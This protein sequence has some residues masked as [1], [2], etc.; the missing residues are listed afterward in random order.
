MF[1]T[2]ADAGI[3]RDDL[4]LAWDFT[5]ASERNLTERMLTI[6]DDAFAQLGD[7]NLA[8]LEVQGN[9]PTTVVT[10]VT[11]YSP[12]GDDGCQEGLQIPRPADRWT[13]PRPRVRPGRERDQPAPRPRARGRPDPA[14][15]RRARSSSPATRTCRCAPPG[16]SSP[17]RAPPTTSRTGSRATSRSPRSTCLIPR[18]VARGRG[19]APGAPVALRARPARLAHRGRGR[20]RQGDGE[21]AQLRVLR[22]RLGRLRRAGPADDRA[23]PAGRLEL[24]EAGRPH[25]AGDAEL[26]LSSAGR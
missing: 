13:A 9:A 17:T 8:D 11:D 15:G 22:D 18:S 16:R 23:D 21:R 26:P 7:T 19:P 20:Q 1:A 4:Y 24:P 25:P 12:C 14:Q 3:A 5:I 2:L 6:R 10:A